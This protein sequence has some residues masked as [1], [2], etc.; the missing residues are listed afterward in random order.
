[1]GFIVPKPSPRGRLWSDK[2][3]FEVYSEAFCFGYP[4]VDPAVIA[5]DIHP[6]KLVDKAVFFV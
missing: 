2:R 1:L 4:G 5:I 3:K 6:V